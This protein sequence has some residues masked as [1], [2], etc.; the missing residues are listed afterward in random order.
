MPRGWKVTQ[1]VEGYGNSGTTVTQIKGSGKSGTG[2][3]MGMRLTGATA[4]HKKLRSA[5]V[6]VSHM[7]RALLIA[8]AYI[9]LKRADQ[10]VPMD[11]GKLR[12]TGRI[13][14]LKV[15]DMQSFVG[16]GKMTAAIAYGD[17]TAKYAF[18]VHENPYP[19]HGAAYNMSRAVAS[20]HGAV[21]LRESGFKVPK[22]RRPQEQYNW[23]DVALERHGPAFITKYQTMMRQYMSTGFGV[24]RTIKEAHAK[25]MSV[26]GNKGLDFNTLL[27]RGG[28]YNG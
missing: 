9:I 19:R 20:A 2:F 21:N 16:G 28:I 13:E 3:R 6:E 1:S 7:M 14:G 25:M 23:V 27:N 18:S 15:S 5:P 26:P 8:N 12:K 17:A 11:K 4:L 24:Q 10:L 22:L